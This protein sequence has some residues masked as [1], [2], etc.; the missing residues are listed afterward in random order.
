M[1]IRP[2][3]FGSSCMP[4]RPIS[5]FFGVIALSLVLSMLSGCAGGWQGAKSSSSTAVVISSPENQTV[6]V[7]QTATFSVSAAV[8]VRSPISGTKTVPP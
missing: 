2:K 4:A 7:G 5:S 6:T 8:A 3:C 1:Q